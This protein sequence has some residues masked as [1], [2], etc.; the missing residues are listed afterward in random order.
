MVGRHNV[1][2][3]VIDQI[4]CFN[5]QSGSRSMKT[6]SFILRL[7]DFELTRPAQRRGDNVQQRGIH[8]IGAS[9]ESIALSFPVNEVIFKR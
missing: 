1:Q 9:N 5:V 4:W 8:R 6:V 2:E 3:G 7:K